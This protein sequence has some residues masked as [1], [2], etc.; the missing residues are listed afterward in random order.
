MLGNYNRSIGRRLYKKVVVS[1]R[2]INKNDNV[3]KLIELFESHHHIQ[4]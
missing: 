3:E 1:Y 4:L 2:E